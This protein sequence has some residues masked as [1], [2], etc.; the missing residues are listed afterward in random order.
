MYMDDSNLP[1]S[2]KRLFT[3]VKENTKWDKNIN[4]EN[5]LLPYEIKE[6]SNKLIKEC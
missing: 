4:K 1:V 3:I 5:M 2:L 6:I